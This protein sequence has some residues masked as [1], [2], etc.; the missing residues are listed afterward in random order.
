MVLFII[1]SPDV[2][3]IDVALLYQKQFFTPISTSS[4]D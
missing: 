2:R 3:G 1:H 4:H